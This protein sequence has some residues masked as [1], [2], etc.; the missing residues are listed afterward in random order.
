MQPV[1]S[2]ALSSVEQPSESPIANEDI[3]VKKV[4]VNRN[5]RNLERLSLAP[6]DRGWGNGLTYTPGSNFP[7]R[8]YYHR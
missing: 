3:K 2:R 7:N 4:F 8:E 6:K 5:P 1:L